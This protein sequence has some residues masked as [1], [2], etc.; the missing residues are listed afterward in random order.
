MPIRHISIAL[1]SLLLA[2]PTSLPARTLQ[3]VLNSG[4]VR[5]GVVLQEPWALRAA[6]GELTGF[7]V[8][9]AR[10]LATDMGV[11]H[12]ILVYTAERII[13]ALE[14]GE[15]DLI[16]A[17]LTISPDRALHVNF[18]QP[19][20]ANGLDLATTR[21]TTSQISELEDLNDPDFTVA[22]VT[23][24]EA[25]ALAVELFPIANVVL[26]ESREQAS[27]ALLEQNVDAYLEQDPLPSYLALENPTM[28]DALLPSLLHE[29]KAGFAV[30]KGDADFLAYLNAWIIARDTDTWLPTIHRYWFETL[31]WRQ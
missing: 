3:Q 1:A 30:N 21:E 17:G 8:D 24:S 19:Y 6:P 23:G 13:Q 25:S 14:A 11:S 22:V 10:K 2:L 15:I 28:I 18:S 4:T 26:F 20:A 5:I 7:E 27:A 12:E 31:R 16:A 29:S 9:V